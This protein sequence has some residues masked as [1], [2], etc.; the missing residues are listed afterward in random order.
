[1]ILPGE[2]N[3]LRDLRSADTDA[4]IDL[5]RPRVLVVAKAPFAELSNTGSPATVLSYRFSDGQGGSGLFRG[6]VLRVRVFGTY[7]S[8]S[9]GLDTD[10]SLSVVVNGAAAAAILIT[11]PDLAGNPIAFDC[12]AFLRF[13]GGEVATINSPAKQPST[14]CW[15]VLKA[16]FGDGTISAVSRSQE[17]ADSWITSTNPSGAAVNLAI[18]VTVSLLYEGTSG[19]GPLTIYGGTMEGL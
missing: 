5:C 13:D 16:Q 18:P 3:R 4:H 2:V 6:D 12:E 9:G 10:T 17:V 15:A 1:M 11:R 7:S 14:R 19:G 8:N